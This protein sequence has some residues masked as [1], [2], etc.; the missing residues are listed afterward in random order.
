MEHPVLHVA[1]SHRA[2]DGARA[3]TPAGGAAARPGRLAAGGRGLCGQMA[4]R[5]RLIAERRAE[6]LARTEGS[7]AA[8]GEAL[9]TVL[10][11]LPGGFHARG[12][13]ITRPDG[14]VV[15]LYGD[16][17]LAVAGGWC[18]RTCASSK[19][20]TARRNTCSPPPP[21]AF[22]QAG[23]CPKRWAARWARSMARRGVHPTMAARVQRMFDAIRPGRPLWRQNALLY[24]SPD[25][26]QPRIG[27]RPAGRHAPTRPT[28]AP[29]GNACCACRDGRDRVLDPHLRA[30]AHRAEPEQRRGAEA[31]PIDHAGHG[32]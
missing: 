27:G 30:A 24:A 23:R 1:A 9:E 12:P 10:A 32:G 28:C 13:R 15:D 21:C 14:V 17:P 5:D 3:A 2:L 26:H 19:D 7:E 29:N 18:R 11:H 25:L 22:R 20:P 4:L 31:F 16:T 8:E 6:V